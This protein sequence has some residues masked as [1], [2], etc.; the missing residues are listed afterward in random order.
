MRLVTIVEGPNR[1]E[2]S[3]A[4]RQPLLFGPSRERSGGNI[5]GELPLPPFGSSAIASSWQLPHPTPAAKAANTVL[6]GQP[7]R[8]EQTGEEQGP[9]WGG[10]RG[11][12]EEV[13]NY[14]PSHLFLQ[15]FAIC[16][17]SLMNNIELGKLE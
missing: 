14:Q 9:D 15:G 10:R 8:P 6:T 17:D 11:R 2:T 1:A 13:N 4:G 3:K 12:G 7:P 5:P 16:W